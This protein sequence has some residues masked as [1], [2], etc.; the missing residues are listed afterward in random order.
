[1]LPCTVVAWLPYA[2]VAASTVMWWATIVPSFFTPILSFRICGCRVRAMKNSSARVYSI[3][4]GRRVARARAAQMSSITISCLP[5]KPP[6]MRGL[7]TR[8]RRT[9]ICR[10]IATW[11]RTWNGIWVLV[12]MTSRSSASSQLITMCGSIVACCCRGVRYSRSRIRSAC[13]KPSAT[14]PSSL[15]MSPARFRFGSRIWV[16]SGSSWMTDT[17]GSI[18]CS[19]SSTGGS[20]S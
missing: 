19:M 17:P 13:L 7:M 4:T 14:F 9:G 1:M 2:P 6:P 8:M 20:T 12:R 5:P 16:E 3:F 11:R 18:A 10:I 15:W